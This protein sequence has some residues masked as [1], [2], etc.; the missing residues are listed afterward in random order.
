[1]PLIDTRCKTC[2]KVHEQM[3]PL[4]MWPKTPP[5]P[6]CGSETEQ[7]HLPKTVSWTPDPVIVYA[8]PDGSMR[9]PGD[10]HG[11]SAHN[12]EKQGFRRIEIRG[13]AEMRRFEGHM[14]KAEYSRAQRQVEQK[15]QG[16]AAREQHSRSELRRQ[17]QSMSERGR[18][19]AQHVMRKNDAKPRERPVDPGFFSEA[20]NM[21]RS[22]REASRDEQ[23]RRRRD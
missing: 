6:D 22:N 3:R 23:G 17:M 9:F 1:M 21:D 11:L 20:Y 15:E 16:R 10:R 12:Y 7:I 19:V 18:S 13:A 8:A 5:C 14:N 4:A 2:E